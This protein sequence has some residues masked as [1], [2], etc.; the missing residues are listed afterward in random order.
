MASSIGTM[1]YRTASW[2]HCLN[3]SNY[4][5][6]CLST[7]NQ[8]RTVVCCAATWNSY[9]GK[10]LTFKVW[11]LIIKECPEVEL[12]HWIC[13]QNWIY[14]FRTEEEQIDRHANIYFC[15]HAQKIKNIF[16]INVSLNTESLYWTYAEYW[17]IQTTIP[18]GYLYKK[19]IGF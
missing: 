2:W 17:G 8:C 13:V 1:R 5:V 15:V 10:L 16:V 18:V 4:L 14:A 7:G 11:F 9:Q 3:S 6:N 19:K 12:K